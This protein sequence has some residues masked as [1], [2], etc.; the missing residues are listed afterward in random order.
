MPILKSLVLK[1]IFKLGVFSLFHYIHRKKITI[2]YAHSI[3]QSSDIA[4]SEWQP[5]RTQH[6]TDQLIFSLKVLD[7]RYQFI[8]LST[9]LRILKK[10]IKPIDNALVI[11]LDDGYLNNIKA[12][13]HIFSQYNIHPTIFVSSA[14]TNNNI[15]FWFDR[16]DYALQQI[17]NEYYSTKILDE[18]FTFDCRSRKKL[19]RSYASF[20]V[21]IKSQFVNDQMMRDY[22]ESLSCLIE[23]QTGK[24]LKQ[25]MQKDS[26]A[27]LASWDQ[28]KEAQ[29]HFNFEIGSHTINHARLS[30]LDENIIINELSQSKQHIEDKLQLTCNTFCYP[31]NSYDNTTLSIVKDYYDCALTTDP[32]L[33]KIG[34]NMMELK[35]LNLPTNREPLN[36]L[37]QISALRLNLQKHF[38]I[39]NSL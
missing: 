30:L 10:E 26:H 19:V 4:T 29:Q 12:A 7:K 1:L 20:R 34:N 17:K 25:I 22:L 18:L 13:G 6:T 37:F 36:I 32:Q 5:L 28:L 39:T 15:P 21:K 8:S 24:A 2:L 33:N 31:D 11:T 23:K 38:R 3:V 14:H 27:Q 16:L 9:A 35:R